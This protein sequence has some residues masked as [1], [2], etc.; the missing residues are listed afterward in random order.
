MFVLLWKLVILKNEYIKICFLACKRHRNTAPS[1][2]PGCRR[3]CAPSLYGKA[4]R[5]IDPW[6]PNLCF[7]L[8]F[9]EL[10]S[11]CQHRLMESRA[12]SS[13]SNSG[14]L[15][16]R[17]AL[18]PT[19]IHVSPSGAQARPVSPK[20]TRATFPLYSARVRLPKAVN[21]PSNATST[22]LKGSRSPSHHSCDVRYL[23]SVPG[24]QG[25]SGI[26]RELRWPVKYDQSHWR[27]TRR[28]FCSCG[29][30]RM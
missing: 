21:R 6:H 20:Y 4:K 14:L 3:Y 23:A 25:G 7:K 27:C 19:F 15:L 8:P 2:S 13:N 5:D 12:W 30:E 28:R 22:V 18:L 11:S 24:V 17:H 26:R 9:S 16:A 29:R 10:T 1:H